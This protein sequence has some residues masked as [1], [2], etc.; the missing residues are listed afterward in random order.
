MEYWSLNGIMLNHAAAEVKLNVFELL[1]LIVDV[2]QS[3]AVFAILF[4]IVF[5]LVA[6]VVFVGR[7]IVVLCGRRGTKETRL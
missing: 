4:G 7:Q 5:G 1:R 3:G 2:G 6:L